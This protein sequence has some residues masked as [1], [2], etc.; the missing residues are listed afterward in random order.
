VLDGLAGTAWATSR[1]G[2]DHLARRL[3][4]LVADHPGSLP[5]TRSWANE[6]LAALNEGGHGSD[7]VLEPLSERLLGA[8]SLLEVHSP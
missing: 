8:L 5:G 7:E 3:A 4:L 6:L 2:D 1:S